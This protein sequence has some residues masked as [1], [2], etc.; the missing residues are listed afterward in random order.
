MSKFF[1]K[2]YFAFKNRFFS[3]I[4]NFLRIGFYRLL[5]VKIGSGC[6]LAKLKMT[7]PN[8]IQIGNNCKIEHGVYFKYASYWKPGK[9]IVLGDKVFIGAHCEFNINTGIQIGEWCNIASGCKFIDHDHGIAKDNWIGPQESVKA[10][11]V[12]QDDVWLGVNAVVLKGVQIGQ[13]AVVAAGAVVT[14]SIPDYEIWGG[15]PARKLGART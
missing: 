10:P 7:W 4:R 8:Q 12:L 13:G 9:S 3:E 2:A 14:K 6:R 5:G 11:I 15:V 1:Q